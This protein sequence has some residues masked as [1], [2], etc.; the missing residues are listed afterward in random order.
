MGS[1]QFGNLAKAIRLAG[2]VGESFGEGQGNNPTLAA[3]AATM[4]VV[5]LYAQ[6]LITPDSGS[7]D[8]LAEAL[9]KKA[10]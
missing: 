5:A 1:N 7:Q 9:A 6:Q 2:E 3:D 10:K 4:T 8:K